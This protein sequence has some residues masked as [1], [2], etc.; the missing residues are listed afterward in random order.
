MLGKGPPKVEAEFVLSCEAA[1][2]RYVHRPGWREGGG[3]VCHLSSA[4]SES[5]K[6]W[7]GWDAA[8]G[9]V[10]VVIVSH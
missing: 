1:F 2:D 9:S 5:V 3:G 4:L 7:S 6:G 8:A 10:A